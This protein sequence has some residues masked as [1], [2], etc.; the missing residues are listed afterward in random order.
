MKGGES[1]LLA[2]A[3]RSALPNTA[4]CLSSAGVADSPWYRLHIWLVPTTTFSLFL[5][6]WSSLVTLHFPRSKKVVLPV[7]DP[8]QR[9]T[10]PTTNVQSANRWKL[11][12]KTSQQISLQVVCTECDLFIHETL[13]VC[14][15]C[16]GRPSQRTP[17]SHQHTNGNGTVAFNGVG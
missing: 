12:P 15:G 10:A 2:I 13:H 6:S 1:Q 5:L 11:P 9:P 7:V 8:F 14:P 3:V 4:S 16:A 17:A